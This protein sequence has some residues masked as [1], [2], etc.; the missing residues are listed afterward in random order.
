MSMA[1]L[2]DVR[3]FRKLEPVA[4]QSDFTVYA[5]AR[6]VPGFPA[7]RIGRRLLIDCTRWEE[8]KKAGGAAFAGG[9]RK[10]SI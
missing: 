5:A 10:E 2:L 3:E 1:H 7:V 8:F 6:S 4:F 9:W